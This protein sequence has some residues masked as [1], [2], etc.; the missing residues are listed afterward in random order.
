MTWYISFCYWL[1]HAALGGFVFLGAGCL[2]VRLCR[3][4]VRR[5]RLIELTLIGCLLAP[6]VPW[7]PGLPHWS[8]GWLPVPPTDA[9]P[10]AA[11]PGEPAMFAEVREAPVPVELIGPTGASPA[12]TLAP[13]PMPEASSASLAVSRAVTRVPVPAPAPSP[14]EIIALIYSGLVAGLFLW[15]LLGVVNLCRLRRA[16]RPAPWAVIDL[17]QEIAGPASSRVRLLASEALELPV[18]FGWGRPTILLPA[19]LCNTGDTAPLR[20]CLAHEWS[21]VERRDVWT[22][23]LAT[24][25]QFFFFYQPLYWWL[26]RQ[27]RLCQDYLADARAAAQ[28]AD[29]EDYAEY[30]VSLARRPLG[31]PIPAT[32][33][34]GDRRSNL[35]RR[36]LMLIHNREPLE[37]RCLGLW[38]LPVILGAVL[39]L[40][41][42]A[43]L[44]LDAGDA[45]AP[46]K[47]PSEKDAGKQTPREPPK[48]ETLQYVGKAT[49]HEGQPIQQGA[50]IAVLRPFFEN[51]KLQRVPIIQK[52]KPQTDAVRRIASAWAADDEKEEKKAADKKA[53]DKKW[54]F[55]DL[56]PKANHKLKEDFHG[57]RFP[58]NNLES[59]PQGEQTL[60]GVKFKIGESLI[61]LTS[62]MQEV[63]D[64]PEKV[65]DI[66]VN[67][68]FAKLHIL[69]A[70]GWRA[71]DDALVGEYT[72]NWENGSSVTIPI[73]YGKDVLDWWCYPDSGEPSNGKV[74]WKG[75]N[76]G[77]K[78]LNAT[79][80][81]YLTTWENPKPE[82]KVKSIDFSTTKQTQAAPFCVA[83]TGEP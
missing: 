2:A 54:I 18:T 44:R 27:L 74:A 20:Y 33:G 19:S 3:Q 39:L 79:I 70:V 22:W 15:W 68:K 41:G 26:R 9:G 65:E 62:T 64:L 81:L 38:N 49:V 40:C 59:L 31:G 69:Q 61:Q 25:G 58:G 28:A 46:S 4:P 57:T 24:L 7:L 56:Q 21:H 47:L 11:R 16:A 55:V 76:E 72:I 83:I 63:A 66:K 8:T 52:R 13:M 32:L 12:R 45:P 14:A 80:R 82:L 35:Y 42:I 1:A 17:F 10:A 75:E 78:T 30:L 5:L 67:A 53:A 77:A 37:Q 6:W 60:E 51:A 71:D 50:R 73:V 48:R 34:M 43:V 29:A 36:V 23:N